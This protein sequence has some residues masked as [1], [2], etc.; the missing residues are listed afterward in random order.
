MRAFPVT[1]VLV[2]S[3]FLA[4]ASLQAARAGAA[5]QSAQAAA[6]QQ[7]PDAP[8]RAVVA[9]VCTQCHG[10]EYIVPSERTVPVWRDTIELMRAYGAEASDEDWKTI[11]SYIIAHLAYVNVNTASAEEVGL[12]FGVDE[13]VAQG[14][15]AYR[16]TQGGFKT[17]EDLK[18][19]PGLDSEKIEMLKPRLMFA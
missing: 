17:I 11:T 8:G 15:V 10:V 1:F 4:A 16:D 12:V 14:V 2:L 13:N 5:G 7:L 3:S 19:A 9:R 18:K 6:E